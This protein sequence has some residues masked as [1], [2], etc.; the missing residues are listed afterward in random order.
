[1]RN[2]SI[3]LIVAL[4]LMVAM[5]TALTVNKSYAQA[6]K[7]PVDFTLKDINGNTVKL[8][9]YRGKV[10]VVD[11]WA[12][13]CGYCV[14]ELPDL[15]QLQKDFEKNKVPAQVIGISMDDN[16]SIVKPFVT[17][18]G[19]NYP[20]LLGTDAAVKTMGRVMGY[21]TKFIINKNGVVVETL[22]GARSYEVLKSTVEKYL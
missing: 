20:I 7:K 14:R 8:S 15:V 10:V 16:R 1:M 4:G 11:V 3:T 12:T 17:Q 18:R 19:I 9:D 2:R 6:A 22:V 5:V 13:W 21:P